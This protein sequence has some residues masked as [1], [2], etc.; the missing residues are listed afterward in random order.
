LHQTAVVRITIEEMTA[1]AK[2][3]KKRPL[4]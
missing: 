1:K 3:P 2:L 4:T